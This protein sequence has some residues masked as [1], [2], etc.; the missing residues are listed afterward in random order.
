MQITKNDIIE[1]IKSRKGAAFITFYAL[2]EAQ[3]SAAK[4]AQKVYKLSRVNGIVNFVYENSVNNQLRREGKEFAFTAK[5]RKWGVHVS[6]S[7]IEHKGKFYLQVKVER[8]LGKPKYFTNG[9]LVN[10][11]EISH[12]LKESRASGQPCDKEVILRD[13]SFDAITSLSMDGKC[14]KLK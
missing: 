10:K 14:Y 4:N 2:T 5:P 11:A 13:Y 3:K 6:P 12:L 7:I 1:A 8:T 9:K